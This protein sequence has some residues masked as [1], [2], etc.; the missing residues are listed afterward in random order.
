MLAP[1]WEAGYEPKGHGRLFLRRA[2]G[3]RLAQTAGL[4]DELY[5]PWKEVLT[6]AGQ[7]FLSTGEETRL[8]RRAGEW[9]RLLGPAERLGLAAALARTAARFEE[10]G[11]LL[12]PL[13]PEAIYRSED[14]FRLEDPFLAALLLPHRPDWRLF[15]DLCFRAPEL[16]RG[17]RVSAASD[18]FALGVTL[19]WLFTGRLPFFD[20]DERYISTRVLYARPVDPRY[21]LPFLPAAAAGAVLALL[22]KDP[23]ERPAPATIVSCFG[24]PVAL[25]EERRQWCRARSRPP[26]ARRPRVGSRLPWAIGIFLSSLFFLGAFFFYFSGRGQASSPSL[27]ALKDLI[28]RFYRL[29]NEGDR[30]GL[31]GLLT[32]DASLS[33]PEGAT[34]VWDEVLHITLRAGRD[35]RRLTA[36][37]RLKEASFVRGEVRRWSGRELLELVAIDGRWYIAS[38]IRQEEEPP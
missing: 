4:G 10:Q 17:G 22:A 34:A 16:L 38:V 30:L 23:E 20:E 32:P 11:V 28:M 37:I 14:G 31:L 29:K 1:L 6:L 24:R 19:Y 33:W 21:Y 27:P 12:G 9:H 36:V 8:R 13:R 25:P 5:R 3:C 26:V 15:P 2:V 7:S 35:R 18:R